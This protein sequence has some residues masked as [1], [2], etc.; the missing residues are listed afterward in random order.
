VARFAALRAGRRKNGRTLAVAAV[1]TCRCCAAPRNPRRLPV[2]VRS[3]RCAKVGFPLPCATRAACTGF[4]PIGPPRACLRCVFS[5]RAI[6]PPRWLWRQPRG[7]S[8]ARPSLSAGEMP[9]ASGGRRSFARLPPG[10]IVGRCGKARTYF[11][12]MTRP[13]SSSNLGLFFSSSIP[14]ARR[15]AFAATR[16]TPPPFPHLR[17]AGIQPIAVLAFRATI[18]L[19]ASG[20]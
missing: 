7:N 8:L 6:G 11:G 20:L 12:T 2:A 15:R 14:R 3:A 1:A 9:L 18:F 17:G 4:A 16:G 19:R 5:L 13:R 10:A